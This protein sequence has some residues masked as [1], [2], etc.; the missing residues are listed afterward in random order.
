MATLAQSIGTVPSPLQMVLGVSEAG[1]RPYAGRTRTVA[2]IV[3]TATLAMILCMTF[4]IPYGFQAAVYALIVSRDNPRATL[5]S[6]EIMSGVTAVTTA[7]ILISAWFVISVPVLHFLWIIFT[8]FIAFYVLST[9]TNYVAV[10]MFAN[11][12][13][14][15]I[16]LWD[17]HVSAGEM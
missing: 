10:T 8:F 11:M 17:R 9:V 7:Y 15:G 14:V 16:P 4:R 3:I 5:E 1:T 6:A 2:R 13:S 12:I